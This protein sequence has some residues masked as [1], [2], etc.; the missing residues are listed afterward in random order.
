MKKLI[1][2]ISSLAVMGALASILLMLGLTS[3]EFVLSQAAKN[4]AAWS[5]VHVAGT[6]EGNHA[7]V[8]DYQ[9][10]VHITPNIRTEAESAALLDQKSRVTFEMDVARSF[11]DPL[12]DAQI[13]SGPP[14]EDPLRLRMKL[15]DLGFYRRFDAVPLQGRRAQPG[16]VGEWYQFGPSDFSSLFNVQPRL[17]SPEQETA[18]RTLLAESRIFI[19]DGQ[20]YTQEIGG[21]KAWVI[22]V[23][24]SAEGLAE[25]HTR[26]ANMFIADGRA[27]YYPQEMDRA[28]HG[29]LTVDRR[30]FQLVG[31]HL[32]NVAAN[33]SPAPYAQTMTLAFSRHNEPVDITAPERTRPIS[34]FDA[35]APPALAPSGLAG[36]RPA[37]EGGITPP[38]QLA[39]STATSTISGT[40]DDQDDDG[41]PDV[42]EEFYGSDAFDPDSDRDGVND[43]VEVDAGTDPIGPGLLYDFRG[44][45]ASP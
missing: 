32:T 44:S 14:G 27:T 34:Q 41:L 24:V 26:E 1:I 5:S 33:A 22:P 7:V 28:W 31:V 17:L 15:V 23:H 3:P 45:R 13:V 8:F 6:V 38:L 12:I 4:A 10:R 21:K 9:Q 11:I 39:S 43:G 36:T 37:D 20:I 18:W 29:T 35:A 30:S 16:Y 40:D 2:A 25:F 19:P 42:L